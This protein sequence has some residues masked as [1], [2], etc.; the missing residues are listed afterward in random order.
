[1]VT[2]AKVEPDRV[3]FVDTWRWLRSPWDQNGV[4]GDTPNRQAQ[5]PPVIINPRRPGRYQPRARK[6]HPPE[7]PLM[8]R[9]RAKLRKALLEQSLAA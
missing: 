2:H 9:P 8:I 1:M 7:Y 6:D 4:T 3:S 5:P